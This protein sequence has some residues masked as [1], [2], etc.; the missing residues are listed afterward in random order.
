MREYEKGTKNQIKDS[1]L[2]ATMSGQKLYPVMP[3]S[4]FPSQFAK[5][6]II[7]HLNSP[8]PPINNKKC[9]KKTYKLVSKFHEQTE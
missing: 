1:L 2:S 5:Q 8:V 6:T 3:S 7:H 9:K 4:D